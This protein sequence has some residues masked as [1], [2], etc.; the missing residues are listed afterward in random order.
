MNW[1]SFGDFIAMGGYGRYVWGAVGVSVVVLAIE[2]IALGRRRRAA[3]DAINER[4]DARADD[5]FASDALA[6]DGATRFS[7]SAGLDGGAA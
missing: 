6:D 7:A 3:I 4:R 5:G 2:Q 1:H